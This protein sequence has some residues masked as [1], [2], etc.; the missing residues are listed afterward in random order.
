M[1]LLQNEFQYYLDN[2][3]LFHKQYEGKFLV[4]KNQKI[5][6]IF[7]D[8]IVAIKET[9]KIHELGTFLVQHVIESEEQVRFH[10]R[11]QL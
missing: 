6:G 9:N 8:R 3:V 2:K 11:Y 4:I 7:E 5:I 1:D 10:S